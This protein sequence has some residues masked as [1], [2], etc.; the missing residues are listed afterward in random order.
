MDPR[1]P[2][3]PIGENP[4]PAGG[5]PEPEDLRPLPRSEDDDPAHD[6]SAAPDD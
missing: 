5:D 1:K 3:R 2:Y 6:S 4:D